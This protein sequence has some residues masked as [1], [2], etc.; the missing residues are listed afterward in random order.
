M[1][2][3]TC[4]G[5]HQPGVLTGFQGFSKSTVAHQHRVQGQASGVLSNVLF[6]F[7]ELPSTPPHY[8]SLLEIAGP[9]LIGVR[10]SLLKGQAGAYHL[11]RIV[12]LI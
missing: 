10:A 8:P 11:L 5:S 9:G 6:I 12:P 2:L 4:D 7:M 1:H 3:D